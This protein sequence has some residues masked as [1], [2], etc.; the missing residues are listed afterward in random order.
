MFRPSLRAGLI[1]GLV[2]SA[3]ALIAGGREAQA[4]HPD[5]FANYYVGPSAY[6]GMPAQMY[7]SP[8][9]VPARVGHTWI[10]YQP[11][12]PHELMYKHKRT[13]YRYYQ[14]GG[15]TSAHVCW[16]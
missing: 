3:A 1:A 2:A 7:V 13:Y 8:R 5:L 12:M 15:W 9:P 6:G 10:T 11:L 4:A 14:N 16:W